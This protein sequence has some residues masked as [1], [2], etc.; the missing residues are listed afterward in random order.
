MTGKH[1]LP[2]YATKNKKWYFFWD[3]NSSLLFF[4]SVSECV[5]AA[6]TIH[7]WRPS[8][9]TC[10][11]KYMYD[12]RKQMALAWG[13]F[14]FFIFFFYSFHFP[15]VPMWSKTHSRIP[16]VCVDVL[17][18]EWMKLLVDRNRFG[19][20]KQKE[21]RSMSFN[22][23]LKKV[24]TVHKAN[25]WMS[26]LPLISIFTFFYLFF[27]CGIRVYDYFAIVQFLL[28]LWITSLSFSVFLQLICNL[29]LD[30][31]NLME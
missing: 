31:L 2:Q 23:K 7:L 22:P 18:I 5:Y 26:L 3:K 4:F 19:L 13:K 1:S 12:F 30:I 15:W 20:W 29:L 17:F 9:F 11:L 25:E 28:H 16:T 8:S 10:R 24:T 14:L 27:F 21:C 6:V